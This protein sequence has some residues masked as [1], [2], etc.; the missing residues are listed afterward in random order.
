M[1]YDKEMEYTSR[2]KCIN[3]ITDW[4]IVDIAVDLFGIILVVL[5]VI[6]P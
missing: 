3:V 5:Q 6:F 2:G 4:L 1:V